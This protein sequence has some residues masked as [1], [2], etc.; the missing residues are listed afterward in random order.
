MSPERRFYVYAHFRV[1]DGTVFYI[2][3][4]CGNRIGVKSVRNARWKEIAAKDGFFGRK[5]SEN[6]PEACALSYERAL[7]FAIGKDKLCNIANGGE[8]WGLTGYKWPKGKVREKSAKCMKPVISSNGEVF[9]SL[10]DAA[11]YLKSIG[12]KGATESHISS[13]CNRKRHVAYGRSWSFDIWSTPALKDHTKMVNA[14]RLR[15]VAASNGIVFKSISDA[16]QWVRSELKVRCGTS[17]I[18]RCCNGKR[19]LCGG[20][21]WK[22]LEKGG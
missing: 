19:K 6:M 22:Y 7:I 2:G 9:E 10:G 20:L 13:C 17:D 15:P 3:K 1:T 8:G 16:A 12:H 14:E 11:R 18:S 5:L 4:G 21:S